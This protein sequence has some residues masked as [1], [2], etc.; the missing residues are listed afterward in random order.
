MHTS[1][2]M[3]PGRPPQM[4]VPLHAF[5]QPIEKKGK[6]KERKR[7]S[8]PKKESRRAPQRPIPIRLIRAMRP[9]G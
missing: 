5:V 1:E 8:N 2:G 9:A 4:G 3:R 7:R 6:R